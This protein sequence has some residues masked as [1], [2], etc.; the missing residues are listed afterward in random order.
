M[1]TRHS[2]M[3]NH[4]F[5]G[6]I[7]YVVISIHYF[8]ALV[9]RVVSLLYNPIGFICYL[10]WLIYHK[11]VSHGIVLCLQVLHDVRS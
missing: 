3:P 1:L 9:C 6:F 7:H 10:V 11:S 8:V 2:A 5:V 4:H